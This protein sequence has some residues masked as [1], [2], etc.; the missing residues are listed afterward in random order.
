MSPHVQSLGSYPAF[1]AAIEN[2]VLNGYGK[3]PGMPQTKSSLAGRKERP[4]PVIVGG[5]HSLYDQ[6]LSREPHSLSAEFIVALDPS[7]SSFGDS[8]LANHDRRICALLAH[9]D[10][11]AFGDNNVNNRGRFE[12]SSPGSPPMIQSVDS[13][14][15]Q[16]SHAGGDAAALAGNQPSTLIV[17]RTCDAF[18][19]GQLIALAEHRALVKAWLWDIDPFNTTKSSIRE[20]RRDYVSDKLHQMRHLLSVGETLD[21]TDEPDQNEAEN[22]GVKGMH[23]ATNTILKHYATRMQKHQQHSTSRTPLRSD[24]YEGSY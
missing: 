17:C 11:L 4:S 12:I 7:I 20:D 19:C 21:G 6:Y 16:S 10:T 3:D 9:A 23:S 8:A 1:V 13:M 15:S 18:S 22:I 5:D 24:N 14:M 2:K